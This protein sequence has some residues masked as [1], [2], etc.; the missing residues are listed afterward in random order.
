MSSNKEVIYVDTEDDITTIIDKATS[1]SASILGIVLPKRYAT[2][3]SSVNM[4]LLKRT[5]DKSKKKIVLITKDDSLLPLAGSAGIFV[6]ESL[7]SRPVVPSFSASKPKPDPVIDAEDPEIDPSTPIEELDGGKV[8]KTTSTT[9]S[10]EKSSKIKSIKESSK[11]KVPNFDRFRLRAVLIALAVLALI[12]GWYVAFHVV[13]KASV[14][15]QAQTSRV[16]TKVDFTVNPTLTEDVLDKNTVAGIPKEISKTV[17]ERFDATGEKDVGKKASG[18]MTVQN[19]DSNESLTLPAGTIFTDNATGFD[20]SSDAPVTVPGGSFSG[21]GCSSPGEA[22]VAVTATQ[23]GDTRNLSARGYSV[24]GQTSFITGFGG[25]MSGGTSEVVKVVSQDDVTKAEKLLLAKT[26][27]N[28][29]AELALLFNESDV[30]VSESFKVTNNKPTPSVKVGDQATEASISAQFT[31]S[32]IGIPADSMSAVLEKKQS[33]LVDTETQSIL[34]N[35]LDRVQIEVLEEFDGGVLALSASTDGFVGPEINVEQ[36]AEEISGKRFSEAVDLIK[37]RP[38]INEV[39]LEL[40]PFWVFS[41]P[42][43][44]KTTI[45]IEISD[46]AAQ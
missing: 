46:D 33:E 12:I 41:V 2:L 1:S 4:K 25:N 34:D 40:T 9:T 32:I 6:A 11:I 31:Y 45:T 37:N 18:Q 30:V 13:P 16:A 22:N 42:G 5:A 38:G 3:K 36:L 44:D 39:D 7:K 27:E 23:S 14:V 29:R 10:S 17:T 43:A 8:T 35:G 28:V 20:F 21:G 24:E 15:I 26:D 19:C